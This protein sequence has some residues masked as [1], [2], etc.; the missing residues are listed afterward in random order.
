MRCGSD[1]VDYPASAWVFKC[2]EKHDRR[3]FS[4]KF[5]TIFED[6]PIGL[7]K[8]LPV[9][10]Q[11]VNLQEWHLLLGDPPCYRRNSEN[12]LVHAPDGATGAP[13]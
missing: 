13:R 8:W 11:I 2:Y 3:K 1:N 7:D 4:L 10:W 9:M 6:F 12:R 5:G